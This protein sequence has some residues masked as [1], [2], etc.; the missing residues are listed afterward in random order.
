MKPEAE[1]SRATLPLQ[2]SLWQV[3]RGLAEIDCITSKT[4]S[5]FWHWYS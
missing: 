2:P 1:T 5:H 3:F 4:L